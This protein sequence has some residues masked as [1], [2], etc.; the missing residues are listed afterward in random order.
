MNKIY[1]KA[2]CILFS[3]LFTLASK[4]NEPLLDS[5]K[6]NYDKRAFKLA[7]EQYESIKAKGLTSSDLYYNLG[8]AY[9]RNGQ[10]GFSILN[11]EK[12]IKSNPSHENAKFNLELANTK[13]ADKFEAIPQ[14]S[15]ARVLVGIN[16]GVSHNILS[17]IAV[18]IFLFGAGLF[19]IAKKDKNRKRIKF[20][21]VLL[22]FGAIITFIAWQQKWAVDEYKAGITLSISSN[23]FS[24]PNPSSTLLF[25]IHE[26]TKLEILSKSGDWL[27]IKAP[28][29]EV[30]WVELK[31]IGEI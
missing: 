11:F 28:N 29:N 5:A 20:A 2:F 30:G 13:L 1:L 23:I 9:F 22:F 7:I 24:E 26:G 8:N 10:L 4:A 15:V 27:N 31:S 16:N 21:K 18:A 12:A 19:L 6:T 14:A 3:L 25:E 17:I